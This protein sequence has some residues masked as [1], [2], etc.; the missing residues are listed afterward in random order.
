MLSRAYVCLLV[1]LFL[2]FVVDI[3]AQN[4]RTISI[5]TKVEKQLANKALSQVSVLI[6]NKGIRTD[7]NGYGM[8][9][10]SKTVTYPIKAS[11][12][13]YV[14]VQD[15]LF[16]GNDTTITIILKEINLFQTNKITVNADRNG[17]YGTAT[18]QIKIISSKELDE[19]RG[20]TLGESLNGQL[21]ITTIQ[22]GSSI[23]KPVLRGLHS[24]RLLIS[25]AGIAQEGQ[26]WGAEHAPEIDILSIG[27]IQ[28]L[29]GAAGVE[30]G[31]GA[32][33]G[34]IKVEPPIMMDTV[35]LK[36][37][38]S[39]NLMSNNRQGSLSASLDGAT[40]LYNGVLSLQVQGSVRKAGDMKS[41]SYV[42]GNTAF[43]EQNAFISASYT[44]IDGIILKSRF[45]TFTSE[46]GIFKGSHISNLSDLLLAI[47]RGKPLKEYDFSYAIA[48]PKQEIAHDIWANSISIPLSEHIYTE[49]MHGWQFND[50]QEFDAHN[51][52]IPNDSVIALN[53]ALSLP[54]MKLQLVTQ[55]LDIKL[56]IQQP[57]HNITS[58]I[59]CSLQDQNNVRSGK[60]VLIPDY[61][62][63]NIGSYILA[64]YID[65]SM[66]YNVGVRYDKKNITVPGFITPARKIQDTSMFFDGLSGAAGILWQYD[67]NTQCTINFGTA[68]RAPQINEL[69][70]NDIHH[71]TA[72]FE[73]GDISL[74]KEQSF[75]MDINTIYNKPDFHAECSIYSIWFDNYIVMLPDKEFPTVT[76]RGT[77]PTFRYS[78]TKAI[79]YGLEL[80]AEYHLNDW[81]K[82]TVQTTITKGDDK[83]NYTPLFQIPA[84]RYQV[85]IH[86]H[87]QEF[88]S[89]F[90]DTFAEFGCLFVSTQDRFAPDLDYANSPLGYQLYN[91][92]FGGTIHTGYD[93][94]I[95]CTMSANNIFNTDYRDYLS[96]YRYFSADQGFN[97]T[98]RC[99][100][101]FSLL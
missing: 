49:I 45:T 6:G 20:Q 12:P 25:N 93:K 50:R 43:S 24:Q 15:T 57:L 67:T 98:F 94:Y 69:F 27:S 66:I 100:Y 44:H 81:S 88:L 74:K 23:S 78:Q 86:I 10:V 2:C 59:G 37:A 32:M 84:N 13:G 31:P 83:T 17:I 65:K 70:S 34:M 95:S 71:G 54:A 91:I 33:G 72:Q 38:I 11:Y 18:Q 73:I 9:T 52:R 19:H 7:S 16:P 101:S 79:I 8:M 53:S 68:W 14:S 28:I 29:K 76:V 35:G 87:K 97:L 51:L 63:L 80:M 58:T 64:N 62:S 92:S 21:G 96:R 36:G 46:L 41:A 5:L 90:H 42:L 99:S 3:N 75:S 85:N 60:V 22:T 82:V 39:S 47:K 1:I 26:Q 48:N 30:Y 61:T 4:M 56:K 55:S 40:S 89:V 77:F